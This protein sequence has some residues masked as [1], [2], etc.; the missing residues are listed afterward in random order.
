[1]SDNCRRAMTE[2][3]ATAHEYCYWIVFH[4][5]LEHPTRDDGPITDLPA[6]G[7]PTDLATRPHILDKNMVPTLPVL[8]YVLHLPRS[9]FDYL[10][11]TATGF[12]AATERDI[13]SK[14][15]VVPSRAAL[16]ATS[17]QL[18]AA[19]P[20][21]IVFF[22]DGVDRDQLEA[23]FPDVL[24]LV[25]F[26][27]AGTQSLEAHWKLLAT[28]VPA[29]FQQNL[30]S[31]VPWKDP[32]TAPTML[33]VRFIARHMHAQVHV[34]NSDDFRMTA[35]WTMQAHIFTFA[36][37]QEHG[38]PERDAGK[39]FD[40][41]FKEYAR[42]HKV[43][44]IVGVPGVSP[45]YGRDLPGGAVTFRYEAVNDWERLPTDDLAIETSAINYMV[46]H[47]ALSASGIGVALPPVPDE[48]F[49]HLA[50]LED[51][52]ALPR[53]EGQGAEGAGYGTAMFQEDRWLPATGVP[54]ITSMPGDRR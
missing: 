39:H 35:A 4:E 19:H 20:P 27:D 17:E 26:S 29:I 2:M 6:V 45:F 50:A 22:S 36:R 25:P 42:K 12:F 49:Y 47:R 3:T 46:T 14:V 34:D 10:E 52:F 32:A 1:M 18:G 23:A 37:M 44:V 13:A 5:H 41:Y 38:I 30:D 31:P 7:A 53:R 28:R 24:A 51:Y 11:L 15:V 16:N 40:R 21:D 54:T 43:D 8:W 48:C 33:P 9:G